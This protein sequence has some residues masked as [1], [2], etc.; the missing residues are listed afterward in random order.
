MKI[1]TDFLKS[2]KQRVALNGQH[3]SW[4]DVLAGVPQGS[5]LGSLLFLIYIN[6]LSDGLQCN[7]KLFADDTSLFAA[8]HN[9]KKATNDLNND[10]TKITKLAFQWKMCF[11]SDISKQVHEVTFSRKRSVSSHPPLTFNNI[12][13][14][15]TSSQKH[16]GMQLD[17]KINFEEHLR[18]VESKV[19]KTIGITRKLQNVLPLSALL[20]IY[21]SFIRPHLDYGD[22]IY[23]KAFNEFFHAKLESFQ[24]NVTLA[25]TGAIRGSCT[26]N[27]YE[28]LGLESLRSRRWYR[29][30]SFLYKVLKSESPSHLFST[31][32]KSNN[33]QHQTRNSDNIPSFFAKHDYLKNSFFPSAIT[34]WN[35]LDCYIRNADS[36]KVFKNRLLSFIDPCPTISTT[37]I[38]LLELNNL[39]D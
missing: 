12:P 2:R 15:Q 16:L 8:V 38:T 11:N 6:D 26:E 24:H 5:I 1:L 33:R 34:E 25:I 32:P 13:V 21:K 14:A 29:K 31:I 28:E 37:S 3:S 17:K 36:F 39:Q 19:N 27:I 4:R 22:V 23:D 10:L 9:I 18:K 7:P 20:T 30:M 35:K